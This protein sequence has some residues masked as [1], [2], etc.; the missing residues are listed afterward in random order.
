MNLS[1]ALTYED[2]DTVASIRTSRRQVDDALEELQDNKGLGS[3]T[4]AATRSDEFNFD[5][6]PTILR[7]RSEMAS[8]VEEERY[9]DAAKLRDELRQVEEMVEC[10]VSEASTSTCRNRQPQFALGESVLHM[11]GGYRGVVCG[12]DMECCESEEWRSL[13]GVSSLVHG[14]AQIYYHLLVDT[15][16]WP[17][18]SEQQPP[19]AYVAE[20]LLASGSSANFDGNGEALVD[21]SFQHPF[22]YLMFLGPDGQGNLL[23]CRQLRDRYNVFRKDVYT[24]EDLEELES[25]ETSA[26]WSD[27]DEDTGGGPPRGGNNRGGGGGS[28]G[29]GPSIPGID[30]RSLM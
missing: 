22:S 18:D 20:E 11:K 15:R 28:G 27:T 26:H 2:F 1:R 24:A 30:M 8:A 4:R 29:G 23:P 21:G 13:T 17:M 10:K 3:G 6:A 5:H 16:D 7:I 9:S 25:D 19:I 14:T 12:W